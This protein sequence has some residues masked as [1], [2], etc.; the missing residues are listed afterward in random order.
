MKIRNGFVSNSSSTS[1]TIVMRKEDFEKY[2][3][4]L[5]FSYTVCKSSPFLGIEITR[6]LVNNDDYVEDYVEET[7]KK[8]GIN[9]EIEDSSCF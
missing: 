9:Y 5:S 6:L 4:K 3:D 7:C 1:F 2:E 8:L